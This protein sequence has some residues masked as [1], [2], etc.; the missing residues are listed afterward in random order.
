MASV[1]LAAVTLSGAASVGTIMGL[2]LVVGVSQAFTFPAW[3]PFIAD[4]V[5]AD[6]L[7][8]AVALNSA[9]FNLTRVIGPALA[10]VLLAQV[11]AGT[12]IALAAAS[13]VALVVSLVAINS[14]PRR[15]GVDAPWLAAIREGFHHTWGTATV[16]ETMLVAAAFGTLA[17]PYIVFL[18]AYAENILRVGPEGLGLLFTAVGAGAI[19]GAAISGSRFVGKRPRLSQGMLAT[20]MGAGLI[21]FALSTWPTVSLVALFFLGLGSI[22]YYATA[23]ATVQL[24]VPQAVVGRVMGVWVVVGFGTTPL[25]GIILG[26]VAENVG[27]PLTLAAAGL[28]ATVLT[29]VVMLRSGPR[30]SPAV[31]EQ[32]G[33]WPAKK[34]RRHD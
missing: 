15:G 24:A 16:R 8:A 25:G 22:G 13:Q 6:R 26:A 14:A 10:G 31:G 18:P 2:L 32:A 1:A 29:P 20:A 9:R 23:N 34:C 12:C 7:R 4:L 33:Q 27:L 28:L 30:P 17:L 5:G 19:A 3:S 21:A 11:G